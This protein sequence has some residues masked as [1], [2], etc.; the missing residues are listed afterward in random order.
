MIPVISIVG[1]SRSGKTTLI[2]HLIRE[3][4]KRGRRVAAVKHA[5]ETFN[6]DH[7]G[8]DSWRYSEA[9]AES[10]TLLGAE[11]SAV[12]R[13]HA[14]GYSFDELLGFA[15]GD[16]DIMLVEGLSSGPFPKIEIH[17]AEL[18]PGLRCDPAD[19]LAVVTDQPLKIDC[20]LF[21]LQEIGAIADLAEQQ[22][23][24]PDAARTTLQINGVTLPLGPFTQ[25]ILANT[26]LGVVKSLKGVSKI[27]T[28]SVLIRDAD[29]LSDDA[30]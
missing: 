17:R 12:M 4:K 18:G 1:H 2:E 8:K 25:R 10:V 19:L 23:A 21:S 26:I 6:L 3:F 15:S 9:G 11:R 16:A 20:K 13:S 28:V 7:R 24:E 5:H 14:P 29:A 27:N 30:G 22:M